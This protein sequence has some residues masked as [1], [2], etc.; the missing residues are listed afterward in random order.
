MLS[1]EPIISWEIIDFISL[2]DH[3]SSM[4]R[5]FFLSFNQWTVI[6]FYFKHEKIVD[7]RLL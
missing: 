4:Q 2:T 3:H 5:S 1:S 6:N 7:L